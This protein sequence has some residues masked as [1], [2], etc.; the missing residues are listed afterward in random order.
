VLLIDQGIIEY[1]ITDLVFMENQK[2]LV[3]K[4]GGS[5]LGQHDTTLEDVVELQKIGRKVVIIH[6]GGKIITEWLS[7]MGAS[8]QFIQG[9][10]VTDKTGLEITTAVLSGVVNKN[11]V[12]E[13]NNLGGRAAGISGVDG[14]FLQGNI[15]SP[16][17]G[18]VGSLTRVNTDLIQALLKAGFVPVISSIS[19]NNTGPASDV[20]LLLNVN[21]DTAAGEIAAALPCEKLIFLTDITGVCD[22]SGKLIP[23]MNVNEAETAIASGVASGGMI[24]KI[25]AGIRSLE[26]VKEARII[27]GRQAHALWKEIESSESGT[28]IQ[29]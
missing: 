6:G 13:I 4:I 14:A 7:K 16:E 25:R 23:R 9:E 29:K 24:P 26:G 28:T 5:T 8:T 20:P 3:V 15:K 21:A 18:Y 11:L 12:A 22:K 19:Y 1:Y 10:R 2:I 17:L 27:D